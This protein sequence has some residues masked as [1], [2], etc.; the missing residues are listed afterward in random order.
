MT[1]RTKTTFIFAVFSSLFFVGGLVVMVY[2]ITIQGAALE[3]AKET[4]AVRSAKNV[5]YEHVVKLLDSS[6]KDRVT[7][8]TYFISEKDTIGFMSEL[9]TAANTIGVTLNT[10]ELS[11]TPATSKD[12][13]NTPGVLSIGVHFRGGET[14]VKRFIQLL[15]NVPYHKKLPSFSVTSDTAA[16]V[17]DVTTSLRITMK[18]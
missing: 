18:P 17:W 15:E 4:I 6:A 9:E 13:V 7:L 5:A 3:A 14:A 1:K 16:D 2:I 12:G 10:T 11:I 8:D